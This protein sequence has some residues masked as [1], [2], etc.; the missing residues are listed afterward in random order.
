MQSGDVG[1]SHCAAL[2]GVS[3]VGEEKAH[4]A[5][6]TKVTS[7]IKVEKSEGSS[8]PRGDAHT[9][10]FP[11]TAPT[12]LNLRKSHTLHQKNTNFWIFL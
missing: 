3:P 9:W 10:N 12:K 1:S 11:G 4:E 8:P 2:H 6:S 7:A 5:S